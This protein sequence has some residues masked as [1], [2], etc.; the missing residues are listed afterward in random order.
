MTKKTFKEIILNL[1]LTS[2]RSHELY[3][4]GVDL[5]NVEEPYHKIIDQLMRECFNEEQIGW[6][7]WFLYERETYGGEILEAHDADGNPICYDVDSLWETV[8]ESGQQADFD[9]R[10]GG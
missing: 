7:D 2:K 10:L 8:S 9:N 1:Q 4:L 6:I 5:M 3:K